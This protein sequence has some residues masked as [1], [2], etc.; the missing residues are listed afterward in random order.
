MLGNATVI[1]DLG[2]HFGHG[3]YAREADYLRTQEWAHTV[4]DILTRR[5]KLGLRFAAKEASELDV[6]LRG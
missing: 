4:D 3:L 1:D 2:A 5:S 6:Y